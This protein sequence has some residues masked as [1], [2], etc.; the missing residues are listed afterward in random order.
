VNSGQP[1]RPYGLLR[2][3]PDEF[4]QVLR[5][6]AF[7]TAHPEVVIGDGGFGTIQARIPEPNGEMVITRYRLAELLDKLDQLTSEHGAHE[8]DARS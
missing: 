8:D 4:D 6:Q 2:L 5:L 7:R 3:V 1:G